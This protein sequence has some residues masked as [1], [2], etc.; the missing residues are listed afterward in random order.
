MLKSKSKLLTMALGMI[1]LL[2]CILAAAEGDVDGSGKIDLRDVITAIKVC[3][4]MT[5]DGVN[6]ESD[7]NGD[8]KI[9]LEEAV[10][11]LNAVAGEMP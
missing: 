5:P 6:L 1:I 7:V 2:P 4:G 10:Y 11:D 8:K 3:A 9:G